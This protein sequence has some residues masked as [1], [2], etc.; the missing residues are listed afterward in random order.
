MKQIEIRSAG[1]TEF[2]VSKVPGAMELLARLRKFRGRL[3][4]S[5]NFDRPEANDRR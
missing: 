4:D 1:S 2:E 5:F 3:P